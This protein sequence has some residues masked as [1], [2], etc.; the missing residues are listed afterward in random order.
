MDYFSFFYLFVVFRRLL[1]RIN[2]SIKAYRFKISQKL[3]NY[4]NLGKLDR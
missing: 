4:F 2:K 3:N 1:D